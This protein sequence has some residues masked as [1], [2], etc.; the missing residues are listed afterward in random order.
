[1]G[2]ALARLLHSAGL[3][4]KTYTSGEDFLQA[5]PGHAPDCLLLDLVLPGLNGLA[6]QSSLQQSGFKLPVVFITASES[7][8]ARAQA[9]QSGAVAWLRKPVKDQALLETVSFALSRSNSDH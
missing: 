5:M 1:M 4:A 9:L 6:V 7:M 8:E 2:K 3:S